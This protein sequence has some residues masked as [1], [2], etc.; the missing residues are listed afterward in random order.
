MGQAGWQTLGPQLRALK[1]KFITGQRARA[2]QV[3]FGEWFVLMWQWWL[4]QVEELEDGLDDVST[5]RGAQEISAKQMD[6]RIEQLVGLMNQTDAGVFYLFSKKWEETVT[7]WFYEYRTVLRKS[8]GHGRKVKDLEIYVK[9]L[10]KTA[11][12]KGKLGLDFWRG[13]QLAIQLQL[14]F[15]DAATCSPLQPVSPPFSTSESTQV[16]SDLS[17]R[18]TGQSPVDSSW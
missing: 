4:R 17:R 2:L 1:T 12:E 7:N 5:R 16:P 6:A 10:L 3:I 14:P 18:S 11:A 9:A 15:G 13:F 8:E